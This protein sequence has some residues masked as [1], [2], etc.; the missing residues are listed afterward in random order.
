MPFLGNTTLTLERALA[1]ESDKAKIASEIFRS[2]FN[3]V[4][5]MNG[6]AVSSDDEKVTIFLNKPL[7][8]RSA[9]RIHQDIR[10]RKVETKVGGEFKAGRRKCEREN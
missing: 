5:E 9:K 3:L 6:V 8:K 4:P 2:L 7:S 10:G 1:V